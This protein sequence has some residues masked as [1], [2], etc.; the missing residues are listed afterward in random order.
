M[1]NF[2]V[3]ELLL[4][5]RC[6]LIGDY[7]FFRKMDYERLIESLNGPIV[8]RIHALLNEQSSSV[9]FDHMKQIDDLR[10]EITTLQFIRSENPNK[11]LRDAC[12]SGD[13]ETVRLLLSHYAYLYVGSA[14]EDAIDNDNFDIARLLIEHG[15]CINDV[16]LSRK[17][18]NACHHNDI[19]YIRTLISIGLDVKPPSEFADIA[20][21]CAGERGSIPI[22]EYLLSEGADIN[23]KDFYGRS[24]LLY[25]CLYDHVDTIEYLLQHGADPNLIHPRDGWTH[26]NRTAFL[27]LKKFIN[28]DRG[29]KVIRHRPRILAPPNI[30][31]YPDENAEFVPVVHAP[32]S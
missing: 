26:T 31:I 18:S 25:A 15:A 22:I 14:L 3:N 2:V 23:A 8:D 16:G 29:R 20:M 9:T 4:F 1:A 11:L 30:R 5:V 12:Y 27:N 17:I 21:T 13:I 24:A 19:E 10:R 6:S 32:S 7:C 28:S